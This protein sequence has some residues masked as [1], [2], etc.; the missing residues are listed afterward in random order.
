[1]ASETKELFGCPF[2]GFRVRPTDDT[3]PR[4]GNRFSEDTMFE[5]PFCGDMVAPGTTECPS[6]H[7]NFSDFIA[8]STHRA[9][10]DHID[11]LLL[12]IINLESSQ[13]KQEDKKSISCPK[14]SWMLDG[15][16]NK[17]PKCGAD[18]SEDAPL[19]CP[20]CGSFVRSDSI[21]CPEC[22]TLFAGDEKAAQEQRT[23][24]HEAISSALTEILS[25][26][27]DTG[28]LTEIEEP[29][30]KP[31]PVEE[32]PPVQKPPEPEPV[33]VVEEAP[34]AQAPVEPVTAPA[35]PAVEPEPAPMK[36]S[37]AQGPKKSKQRKLK[38]KTSGAKS[39][40]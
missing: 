29:E 9:S 7:V 22:G 36:A 37:S 12:E 17:C 3:C 13:I 40:K 34:V 15:T 28:S 10:E 25:S 39:G 26:A 8:K 38:A 14:C 4:C 30:P 27:G 21:K 16:E 6:C 33:E 35:E 31:E 2:C 24:Q 18:F 20:I 1:M 23:E 19:Q 32:P 5:C 11:T